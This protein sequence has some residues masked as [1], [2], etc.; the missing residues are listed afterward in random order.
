MQRHIRRNITCG[1]VGMQEGDKVM[2][3]ELA[4]HILN[5]PETKEEEVIQ[6][7]Y[8]L[9]LKTTNPEDDPEG[10]KR[11]RQAY[12]VAMNYARQ[13]EEQQEEAP[14]TEVDLW[15]D[16]VNELYEDLP[17]R[18]SKKE[19]S[20]LLE[21]EVCKSL[22]TSLEARE[23]LL[24]YLMSH[25]HLPHEVWKIMDET[26]D[27]V[28]DM[29][30]L[31]QMFPGDFLKYVEHYIENDTFIPYELFEYR[32]LDGENAN[33]DGYINAYLDLKRRI[34]Q[35]DTQGCLQA[36]E[37]LQAYDIY[38]PFE[39][40]ERL[41][42]LTPEED[43]VQWK[44]TVETLQENGSEYPYV[45]NVLGEALWRE[46]KEEEAYKVWKEALEIAP[47]NVF[48]ELNLVRYLKEKKRFYEAREILRKLSEHNSGN[49]ELRKLTVEVNDSLIEEY[50]EKV[51]NGQGDENFPGDELRLEL[52]W[53][54]L[55]NERPE[56]ARELLENFTPQ[57]SEI[58]GYY[59]V[60]GRV[61]YSLTEYQKALPVLEKW[62][63]MIRDL[64]EDGTEET[65]RRISRKNMAASMLSTCYCE[66]K[67][68]ERAKEYAKA[69]I[70]FATD[71]SER[72]T[73]MQQLSA[74]LMLSKEYENAVDLCDEIIQE[75]ER[76]YP[77]Y[78]I[79]QEA[80]FKLGRAQEVIDD[81]HRSINIYPGFYKPYLFAA[82][83]FLNYHQYEDGMRILEEA[84][85]NGVEFST[86]MKLCEIKL[87]RNM[88]STSKERDE[89]RLRFK[90]LKQELDQEICDIEDK[91]EVDFE[92]GLL[93]WDEQELKQ[94]VSLVEKAIEQSPENPLYH[95]IC[96]DIYK[97]LKEAEKSLEEYEEAVN[98]QPEYGPVY[99]KLSEHYNQQYHWKYNPKDLEKA[100]SYADRYFELR[101]GSYSLVHRGL[102]Y[103]NSYELE[104][105]VV[106]FKKSL[107]YFEDN[108][109]AWNNLGCCYKYLG[110]F[111][112][113]IEVLE[114]ALQ[115]PKNGPH[116]L[117]YKNLADCYET[118]GEYEKAIEC[119]QKLSEEI[120]RNDYWEE[121]GDLYIN[122]GKFE[123]AQKA[124]E[125]LQ[126][127]DSEYNNYYSKMGDLYQEK[128]DIDQCIQYY[129]EGTENV[130]GNEKA[131]RYYA[132]G[133]MY[134][135]RLLDFQKAVSCFKKALA[136]RVSDYYDMYRYERYLAKS[137][138]FLKNGDEAKKHAK[139]AMD[140]YLKAEKGTIEDA[141]NYKPYLPIHLSNF[142]WI[143]LCL[144]EKEKAEECFR[145]MERVQRCKS[146]HYKKCFESTLYMGDIYACEGEYE[147][148]LEEYEETLRRNPHCREAMSAIEKLKEHL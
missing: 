40:V 53:C 13:S 7:A 116:I 94:A 72:L 43:S 17:L 85:E 95:M 135:D 50:K 102:I 65:K 46:G 60:Y 119:Y 146:C 49:E 6:M 120:G 82:K 42:L 122:S 121:I 14:K 56:E 99:E 30:S 92:M 9:L 48:V 70:T 93:C 10:F 147:K 66:I 11:L 74:V 111:E 132:M 2:E 134:C 24:A 108:W 128:G 45:K 114:R 26:F 125:N 76:Y 129:E 148:A 54:L 103:L 32:S 47:N 90:E 144:G 81:Y 41:R 139:I 33:G 83:I 98:R 59:N 143:Y 117:P 61:L 87:L 18:H 79:R 64:K 62:I 27:I 75:E 136:V 69:A 16:E 91:S 25:I 84:R 67:D 51:F 8:R 57:E 145:K 140:A 21:K 80:C 101:E 97:E 138:Y 123:E 58:Y 141:L 71:I 78:L 137:Y 142:G 109:A 130:F 28:Q 3:K 127:E 133:E 34:D 37:D 112:E 126:Y 88:A 96:G 100:L 63:S 118:L 19:W 52:C 1:A 77:A 29:D 5:L 12:E 36:L 39:D 110:R 89:I 4:F 113:A 106:D 86:D 44:K 22:E 115:C 73:S 55:Q 38:H 105:A 104:S 35:G 31:K 131:R 107:E 68:Y 23:K 20:R 15:L 124:Y